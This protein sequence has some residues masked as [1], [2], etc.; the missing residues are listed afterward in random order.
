L[1]GTNLTAREISVLKCVA[2]GD[3]NARIGVRLRITEHAVKARI[4][5]ILRK[6]LAQDRAHAVTIARQRGFIDS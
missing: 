3:S 5:N 4:K 1:P 2:E 6:L